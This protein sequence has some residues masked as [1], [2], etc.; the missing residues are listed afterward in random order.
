MPTQTRRTDHRRRVAQ[1]TAA[2]R[3]VMTRGG[4][5]AKRQPANR[6]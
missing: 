6:R 5:I 1:E 3:Q 2:R 4:K